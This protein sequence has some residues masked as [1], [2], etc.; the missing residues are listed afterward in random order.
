MTSSNYIWQEELG[1]P[2]NEVGLAMYLSGV[3]MYTIIVTGGW[4]SI[5]IMDYIQPHSNILFSHHK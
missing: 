4:S 3:L 1:F 2:S 5:A